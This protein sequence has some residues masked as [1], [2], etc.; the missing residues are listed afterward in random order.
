[1]RGHKDESKERMVERGVSIAPS[2][3]ASLARQSDSGNPPMNN[4]RSAAEEDD[5]GPFWGEVG[6]FLTWRV[7]DPEWGPKYG[8]GRWSE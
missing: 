7:E 4:A 3:P 6:E 2:M 5:T 8:E 1:M